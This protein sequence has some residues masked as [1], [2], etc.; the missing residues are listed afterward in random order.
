MK[1]PIYSQFKGIYWCSIFVLSF[2]QSSKGAKEYIRLHV[3]K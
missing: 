2:D 3:Q 1:T